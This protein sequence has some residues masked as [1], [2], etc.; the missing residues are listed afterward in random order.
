[1]AI[2]GKPLAGIRVLDLT[3]VYSGPYTTLLLLDLGAEVI[4]IEGPHLGD[5]T[6]SFPHSGMGT[7]VIFTA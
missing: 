3:W 6:R 4:K 7:A 5:H 2:Q 1:M